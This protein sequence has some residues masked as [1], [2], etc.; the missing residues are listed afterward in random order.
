MGNI[1]SIKKR[2]SSFMIDD[3]VL[4]FFI[5]VI[6][7]NQI[8]SINSI[9]ALSKFTANNFL[10]IVLIKVLYHWFL[11]WQN[12]MTIGN[13]LM[14]IKVVDENSLETLNIF[15]ALSRSMIRIIS[16]SIFYIGFLFAFFSPKVQTFH[17]K[18]TNA[19][20]VNV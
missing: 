4:S 19:V 1:A 15:M 5:L 16:E 10:I 17:D 12:G 3:I 2:I 11:V 18:F 9:E 6:F 20:V 8:I 13:Y 7:Y 14:K